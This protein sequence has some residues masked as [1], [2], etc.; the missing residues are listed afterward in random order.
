[1]AKPEKTTSIQVFI[2]PLPP[3]FSCF[4]RHSSFPLIE[5]EQLSNM[6]LSN[7]PE[8]L[9]LLF[10]DALLNESELNAFA[11]TSRRFYRILNP[12]LYRNNV[13]HHN[14]SALDSALNYKRLRLPTPFLAETKELR[15]YYHPSRQ[16]L[17][18]FVPILPDI[19]IRDARIRLVL[20]NGGCL[21]DYDWT[22]DSIL[23]AHEPFFLASGKARRRCP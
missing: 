3:T 1:M 9:V 17:S 19:L 14:S 8:E 10:A 11:R 12:Y 20:E 15:E 6:P 2:H 21:E 16:S 23:W 5:I 13:R 22:S 18:D 7:L 4:E